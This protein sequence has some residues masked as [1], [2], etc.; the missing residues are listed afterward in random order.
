MPPFRTLAVLCQA[1]AKICIYI[2]LD[3]FKNSDAQAPVPDLQKWGPGIG[4]FDTAPHVVLV[5][6]YHAISQVWKVNFTHPAQYL[7]RR[8]PKAASS[9]EGCLGY[10]P[11]YLRFGVFFLFPRTWT[12]VGGQGFWWKLIWRAF[13]SAFFY[14]P[15]F[16]RWLCPLFSVI[17]FN[18]QP[19]NYLLALK[20]R[21]SLSTDQVVLNNFIFFENDF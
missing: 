13:A 4:I 1:T 15:Y 6:Q 12:S 10:W 14:E 7:N 19:T 9:L 16:W 5:C 11:V 8:S 3:D 17:E 2:S 18:Q 20:S 21:E